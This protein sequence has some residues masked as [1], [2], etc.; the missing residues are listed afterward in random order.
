MSKY[1]LWNL[2]RAG[3]GAGARVGGGGGGGT[4]SAPARMGGAGADG[5]G[6]AAAGGGG[7][8]GGGGGKA[9]RRR[10]RIEAWW[11][12]LGACWAGRERP[13]LPKPPGHPRKRTSW[14][15]PRAPAIWH[16][17][18]KNSNTCPSSS[19]CSNCLGTGVSGV[20]GDPLGALEE[21]SWGSFGASWGPPR[22]SSGL[23]RGPRGRSW[24]DLASGQLSGAVV[25]P[26]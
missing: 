11:G 20:L 24:V 16:D 18:P 13:R 5:G 9:R 8:G 10:R 23:S 4:G 25:S 2:H 12:D 3:A 6:A 7:G 1:R 22:G 17:R 14:L 15:R 21:P 26:A 19:T